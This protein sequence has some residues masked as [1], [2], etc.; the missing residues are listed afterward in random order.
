MWELML[1]GIYTPPKILE[2]ANNKWG[3]RT[4][5]GK[6]LSRSS[7]YRI[8][9]NP[10]YSGWFEYPKGSGNWYKGKHEPMIT[11][12]EYDRVQKEFW[13]LRNAHSF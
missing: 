7:I 2:I 9:T 13:R 11:Q 8:F 4:R 6:V 10:F 1:R 5:Q 3:F 12:E